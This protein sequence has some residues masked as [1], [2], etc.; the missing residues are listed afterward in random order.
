MIPGC[1][2]FLPP[3]VEV[4]VMHKHASRRRNAALTSVLVLGGVL[5]ARGASRRRAFDFRGRTALI[6]GGSRGLGLL[7]A[8][9]LGAQGAHVTLAARDEDEL[10]RAREQLKS[11]GIDADI[12]V[13]DMSKR[14]EARGAV[15][16]V[17]ARRGRLDILVNNAGVI[18]VGPIDHM[19]VDDFEHEMAVH[20]WGPLHT[21]L[22]A[23]PYMREAG[24]GR[25]VNISSVGGKVAVPHLA[26][27]CASKFALTGV[28]SAV[29]S[30][31]ARDGIF[32]TTVCPGLMRTGSPFNARFKGRHRQE[33][34]WFAI[35]DSLPLLSIDS[36]RAASQIV[37]ALRRGDA[38]LVVSLPAKL[39]VAGTAL[40]PNTV[41]RVMSLM[42]RMLPSRAN[43][44]GDH[45]RSGWQSFS[46][47][48]PSVLTRLSERSAARNNEMARGSL[49]Y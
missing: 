48:A 49:E 36:G 32:V 28:S 7:I 25:I 46:L 2:V 17:V 21:M 9:E 5:L 40:M 15:A 38:D 6:T 12:L 22:A 14:S 39:A 19:S 24:G 41:A 13:A 1:D 18:T 3:S 33:F 11:S 35:A 42:N 31:L 4:R 34:A 10:R 29:G 20:F 16:D 45:E 27:Y 43:G 44:A 37:R 30:E 8:R 23:I 26:P 47:W